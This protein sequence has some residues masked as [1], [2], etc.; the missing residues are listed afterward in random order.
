MA[1]NLITSPWLEVRRIT[2]PS[3]FISP[4]QITDS[5]QKDPLIALAFPRPDWNAAVLEFL[6]GLLFVALPCSDDA[7]WA[8]GFDEP[9]SP[10]KLQ[11]AFEPLVPF[12]NFDGDGPRAFQDFQ[13]LAEQEEKSI[14][15]LL[16]DA[17]GENAEKN[18]SDL[19]VKRGEVKG[20]SLPYAAAALITLQTYSPSGGAGHR[21]SLRGGGPLTT[22][23]CPRRKGKIFSTL[24]DRIWSNVPQ[25]LKKDSSFEPALAFPWLAKTRSSEKGQLVTEEGNPPALAFFACPRRIRLEV[26]PN[27]LCDFSG[28]V[29]AGVAALRTQNYG[30][31]YQHWR[32]PLSPYRADKKEGFLPLHPHAGLSDYGDWL[33]WWGMK[34]Q[35]AKCQELWE[36]RQKRVRSK[37]EMATAIEACG[38]DMD[39][40]KA[41][42]W[43]QTSIPWIPLSHENSA[44]F[45]ESVAL[46]IQAADEA[47]R[48]LARYAK[49]ALYGQRSEGGY[50]IPDNLSMEALRTIS[51]RLW[52]ESESDFL[53][54]LQDILGRLD[55]EWAST[56][57]LNEKWLARLRTLS[58]ALFDET[59]DADAL[60]TL[61]PARLMWARD[62]LAFNFSSH[63]K[64]AVTAALK[65]TQAPVK[66]KGKRKEASS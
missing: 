26:A 36:H 15:T 18:N 3:F 16:I 13:N 25:A 42:Q 29:G 8:E 4:Q 11:K 62:K 1:F 33:A 30:A 56:T 21:T 45:M 37:L 31:C 38:F 50:R 51:E 54:L 57:D 61:A 58:L 39:N 55:E 44:V 14:A 46:L 60:T 53:V 28:K 9:P 17:P 40:M 19:F 65:L 35:P 24:W 41:R 66:T 49:I 7:S 34:G 63:T 22:L 2:G 59:V 12:F 27:I 10:Q 64:A 32:H 43:L 47:A 23:V 48:A 52:S 20:L 5:F 6:I